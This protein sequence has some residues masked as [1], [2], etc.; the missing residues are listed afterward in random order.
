MFI[1]LSVKE[2]DKQLKIEKSIFVDDHI[3]T[4]ILNAFL[5]L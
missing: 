1:Y 5:L 4:T 2:V 3:K